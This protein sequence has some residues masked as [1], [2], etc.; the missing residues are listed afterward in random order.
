[1]QSPQAPREG[2]REEEGLSESLSWMLVLDGQGG[3]SC[4]GRSSISSPSPR[5]SRHIGRVIRDQGS[6][7]ATFRS[8]GPEE[9][10][11]LDV[12]A[13][14]LPNQ[15]DTIFGGTDSAEVIISRVPSATKSVSDL[16]Y[17]SVGAPL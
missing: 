6:C 13:K 17:L 14:R 12:Q 9:Y 3:A 1:M 10:R 7:H 8:Q 2:E 4:S 16:D 11:R 15:A 5:V